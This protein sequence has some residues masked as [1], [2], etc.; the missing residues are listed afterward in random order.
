VE[1]VRVNIGESKRFE[2]TVEILTSNQV[3]VIDCFNISNEENSLNGKIHYVS[4]PFNVESLLSVMAQVRESIPSGKRVCW[5]FGDLTSMSIGVPEDELLRFCW[6][7][8]RYHKQKGDLSVYLMDEKAHTGN[9]FAKLYQLSDVFIKL[10]AEEV[11][12]E[13]VRS[14]QVMKGVFPF[15]SKRVFYDIE[16]SGQIQFITDKIESGSKAPAISSSQVKYFEDKIGEENFEFFTTGIP[17]L[18]FLLGGGTPFNSIIVLSQDYGIRIF[19]PLANI[20]R[21]VAGEK[22]N[23]IN[24]N[25]HYSLSEFLKFVKIYEQKSGTQTETYRSFSEGTLRFIDCFNTLMSQEDVQD[26]NIYYVSNPFNV[27]KLL[28]AMASVRNGVPEDKLVFWI[29]DDLTEM[30]IG[31]PEE[32]LLI[33]CRRAFRYHKSKGDLALYMINEK[34]HSEMFRA[35][36]Y[37]LSD[38]YIRLLGENKPEGIETRI[39]VMKGVFNFDSKKTKYIIDE[40]CQM[41]LED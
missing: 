31:L 29:F 3:S 19:E 27:N 23:K 8:F 2:K 38:V 35:K 25:F 1:R 18:N 32:E 15:Q 28:S 40:K 16:Q 20:F 4:N 30:G 9:F 7:A 34:A 21:K 11:S 41:Q 10:I 37:K 22:I 26:G 6:R 13:I 12:G 5:Y 14:I 33:F 36:L 39:Q 17:K 24:I